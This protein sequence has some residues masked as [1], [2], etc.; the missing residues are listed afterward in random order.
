MITIP[1]EFTLNQKVIIRHLN[2]T[3]YVIGLSIDNM[4]KQYNV[5][6]WH[7]ECRYTTWLFG[8]ELID[9]KDEQH[10]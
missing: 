4:G 2:A 8:D 1:F 6:Y 9:Y 5:R 7:D 10:T 3:G